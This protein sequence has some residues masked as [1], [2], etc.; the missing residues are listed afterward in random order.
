MKSFKFGQWAREAL[1]RAL[2]DGRVEV[3]DMD[4][5]ASKYS[6]VKGL[7]VGRRGLYSLIQD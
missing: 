7:G 2:K 5:R 3:I 6:N 1:E 4:D